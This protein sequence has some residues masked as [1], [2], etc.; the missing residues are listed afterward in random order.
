MVEKHSKQPPLYILQN[1]LTNL[2]PDVLSQLPERENLKCLMHRHRRR[3]LPTDLK[4]IGDL[5]VIPNRYQKTLEGEQ[6]LTF[7]SGEGEDRMHVFAT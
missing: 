7:D 6:F 3:D 5:G 4:T 2:R 1:E